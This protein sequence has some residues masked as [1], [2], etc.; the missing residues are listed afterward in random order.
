MKHLFF[1]NIKAGHAQIFLVNPDKI[2]Y[3][4]NNLQHNKILPK[5]LFLGIYIPC[6][7]LFI[8]SKLISCLSLNRVL[9]YAFC[10]PEQGKC[11]HS[12]HVCNKPQMIHIYNT[13]S[14]LGLQTKELKPTVTHISLAS[15]VIR[16]FL[17]VG[18]I[19]LTWMTTRLSVLKHTALKTVL[20]LPSMQHTMS[21]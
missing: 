14:L 11:I 5:N 19:Q 4:S 1:N 12:L 2:R 21:H 9:G 13:P 18:L 20:L 6:R 15:S 8:Q 7:K 17:P 16:L 3:I 10:H